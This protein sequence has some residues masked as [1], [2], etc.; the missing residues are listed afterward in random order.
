MAERTAGL[1]RAHG[2][3]QR[4]RKEK[5]EPLCCNSASRR[6]LRTWLA[7]V[8][9]AGLTLEELKKLP[10]EELRRPHREALGLPLRGSR[11]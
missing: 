2:H 4:T 10:S 3:N 7:A 8:H 1:G 9:R 11:G 5:R 6:P